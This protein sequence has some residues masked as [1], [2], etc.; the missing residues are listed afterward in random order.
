MYA[1]QVIEISHIEGR[2]WG[3]PPDR[4]RVA[5]ID[6][7]LRARFSASLDYI[8]ELVLA[9]TGQPLPEMNQ[10]RA[11][12][13]Q[14]PVS[15]WLFCLYSKL[16]A[17]LSKREDGDV[18]ESFEAMT[19]VATSPAGWSAVA[20]RAPALSSIWWD[21]FHRLLDTDRQRPF[22]FAQPEP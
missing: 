22:N 14:G 15:P 6:E 20:Y 7:A 11:R 3:L 21:H 16:V 10:L 12:L 5:A 17:E 13:A 4:A 19:K 9:R 18:S 2:R 1:G 8:G